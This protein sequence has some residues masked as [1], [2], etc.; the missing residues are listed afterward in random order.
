MAN[1]KDYTDVAT[2]I[3]KMRRRHMVVDED[4][5]RQWLSHVNY[6]RL[7]G[8]WYTY[9]RCDVNGDRLDEFE[10]GTRFHD[11]AQLYEFDRK[12]RV[13][14]LDALGRVE[15]ALRRALSDHLGGID[16]LAYLLPD[17]YRPGFDHARWTATAES[18]VQRAVRRES[19]IAHQR[20]VYNGIPIWILSE[21]LDFRDLSIL[22]EGLVGDDQWKVARSLGIDIAINAVPDGKKRRNAANMHPL[23]RWLEQLCIVRNVCAHHG[24]L[25]NDSLIPASTVF[26]RTTPALKT[27]PPGQSDSL[28]GALLVTAQMLAT[29]SPGSSWASRVRR[30]I[31][32]ELSRIPGRGAVDMGFPAGWT[33]EQLWNSG[34]PA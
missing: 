16:P 31:E 25:W 4:E 22:Y 3:E 11:I 17:I 5:A 29:N 8:Y 28:Y 27:L 18:R 14:V 21:V 32:R 19:F 15:V 6:Y 23:A 2:Q 30:L 34:A 1:V 9:R 33:E 20:A 12:L 10:A 13:L 7:S 24:R 26:M